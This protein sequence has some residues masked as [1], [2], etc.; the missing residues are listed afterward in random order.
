MTLSEFNQ[1]LEGLSLA[2]KDAPTAEQWKIILEKL[3]SVTIMAIKWNQAG[4][5]SGYAQIGDQSPFPE[6]IYCTPT[7]T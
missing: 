3:N 4:I 2:I 6:K 5:T 1:W 7:S